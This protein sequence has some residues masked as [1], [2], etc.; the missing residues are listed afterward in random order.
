M[1]PFDNPLRVVRTETLISTTRV[2]AVVE[3]DVSMCHF[4]SCRGRT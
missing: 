2:I 4:R 3:S 1:M